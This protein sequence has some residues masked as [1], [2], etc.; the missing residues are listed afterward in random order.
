[1]F[2]V[3]VY[4]GNLWPGW[5]LS[6]A[7]LLTFLVGG[8]PSV[9]AVAILLAIGVALTL[10]PVVYVALERLIFVKVALVLTL[11]VLGLVLVVD[12]DTWRALPR[13]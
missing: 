13:D 8:N 9:I 12:A 5:A 4:F 2:A 3:L 1:V 7:T 11:V 6:S 10:A